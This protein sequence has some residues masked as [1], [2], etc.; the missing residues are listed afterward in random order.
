MLNTYTW[1]IKT[2][3]CLPTHEGKSNVVCSVGFSVSATDGVNSASINNT[4]MMSYDKNENFIE[5]E[6]LTS[7]TV[8]GWVQKALGAEGITN[9]QVELDEILSKLANPPV[10]TRSLPWAT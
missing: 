1:I 2:L 10:I 9:T 8:L 7:D 5:Y 4:L 6:G 3:Q